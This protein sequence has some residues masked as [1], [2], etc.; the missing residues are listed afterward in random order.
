MNPAG[1]RRRYVAWTL[2]AAIILIVVLPLAWILNGD[3]FMVIDQAVYTTNDTIAAIM[4]GAVD[5]SLSAID[6]L[7]QAAGD[8]RLAQ[9]ISELMVAV[10]L[11]LLPLLLACVAA[12][13]V[14][15]VSFEA[16][17]LRATPGKRLLGLRVADPAGGRLPFGRVVLRHVGGVLSWL[18]LNIG[19]AMAAVAPRHQALHDRVA[20]AQVLTSIETATRLPVWARVWVLLLVA[21]GLL[22]VHGLLGAWQGGLA[23][24]VDRA[25]MLQSLD[26]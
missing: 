1:F 4:A 11:A 17:P 18:S 6:F 10:L 3:A 22:A 16:S 24:A 19:H 25:L 5:S 23:A 13:L 7:W 8:P 26:H 14:Y 12:L 20:G 21:L 9:A 2:D 15:H